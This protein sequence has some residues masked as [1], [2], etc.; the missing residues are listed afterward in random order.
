[1]LPKV[2]SVRKRCCF[3]FGPSEGTF[4][5]VRTARADDDALGRTSAS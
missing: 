5:F 4:V 2:H 1:M 3:C